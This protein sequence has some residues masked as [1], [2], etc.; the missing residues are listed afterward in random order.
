V[1]LFLPVS[2]LILQFL[3]P[4]SLALDRANHPLIGYLTIGVRD[5]GYGAGSL[6]DDVSHLLEGFVDTGLFLAADSDYEMRVSCMK[7]VV[8]LIQCNARAD[9]DTQSL[10]GGLDVLAT[11]VGNGGSHGWLLILVHFLLLLFSSLSLHL[12]HFTFVTTPSFIHA[13]A[14]QR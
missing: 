10:N 5:G 11:L 13:S 7:G 4:A 14:Y 8:N 12:R 2:H 9:M 3:D 6:L 1:S